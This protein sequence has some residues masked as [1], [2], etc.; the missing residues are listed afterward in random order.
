LHRFISRK[1][2]K[3]SFL[4]FAPGFQKRPALR[5]H[6]TVFRKIRVAKRQWLPAVIGASAKRHS[7]KP[8]E[9]TNSLYHQSA[10]SPKQSLRS[11]PCCRLRNSVRIRPTAA[12]CFAARSD[13]D[14]IVTR[15]IYGEAQ[16]DAKSSPDPG[17]SPRDTNGN[18]LSDAHAYVNENAY[19]NTNSDAH[20]HA[21]RYTWAVDI[22]CELSGDHRITWRGQ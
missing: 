21:G 18:C 8:V 6:C 11:S 14:S 2:L 10:P 3:I 9:N 12:A 22:L 5:K 7:N 16:Y 17:T 19:A 4:T 13:V 1:K 15:H 20:L